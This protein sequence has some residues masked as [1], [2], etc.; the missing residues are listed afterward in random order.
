MGAAKHFVF[1]RASSSERRALCPHLAPTPAQP[2]PHVPTQLCK[3]DVLY[4]LCPHYAQDD[5]MAS[6]SQPESVGGAQCGT[7][8]GAGVRQRTSTSPGFRGLVWSPGKSQ[9][10]VPRVPGSK[11]LW[12]EA[13]VPTRWQPHGPVYVVH[14]TLRDILVASRLTTK[15]YSVPFLFKLEITIRHCWDFFT[16]KD[17]AFMLYH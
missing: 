12:E 8:G 1:P 5:L 2:W 14:H 10:W 6:P 17:M 7:C 4:V 3:P 15:F 16:L 11:R 13:V 9:L